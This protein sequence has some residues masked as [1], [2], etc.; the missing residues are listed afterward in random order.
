MHA[1]YVQI[2]H[3]SPGPGGHTLDVFVRH[4]DGVVNDTTVAANLKA[5]RASLRPDLDYNTGALSI[6]FDN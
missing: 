4:F 6:A 5:L 1:L 3:Y 2:D